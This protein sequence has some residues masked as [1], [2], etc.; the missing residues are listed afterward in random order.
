MSA[1]AAAAPAAPVTFWWCD[2]CEE[3]VDGSRVTFQEHHDACGHAVRCIEQAG[4][5]DPDRHL[6]AR[7]A[8]TLARI[9]TARNVPRELRADAGELARDIGKRL[10]RGE[11]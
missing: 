3:E 11:S 6:L 7:T 2:N 5:S 9:A 10:G 4:P 1:P 8:W